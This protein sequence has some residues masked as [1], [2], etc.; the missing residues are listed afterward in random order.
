M[1]PLL[2]HSMGLAMPP[3]RLNLSRLISLS[4]RPSGQYLKNQVLKESEEIPQRESTSCG[5]REEG[6]APVEGWLLQAK[7]NRIPVAMG[8][9]R[10]KIDVRFM[11]IWF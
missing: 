4:E 3:N 6:V 8:T 1:Y 9:Q 5:K 11:I 10:H 7:N 2:L